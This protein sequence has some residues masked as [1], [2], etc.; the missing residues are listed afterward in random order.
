VSKINPQQMFDK[1]D[2]RFEFP[3]QL[4]PQVIGQSI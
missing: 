4:R 1:D 2:I 3:D